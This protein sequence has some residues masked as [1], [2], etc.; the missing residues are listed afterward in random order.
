MAHILSSPV[1]PP[2]PNRACSHP[3]LKALPS[4]PQHSW[5]SSRPRSQT[6]SPVSTSSTPILQ[7]LIDPTCRRLYCRGH[8]QC[9]RHRIG[10]PVYS[11]EQDLVGK[12]TCA[13]QAF[14]LG[15]HPSCFRKDPRPPRHTRIYHPGHATPP[16]RDRGL[17]LRASVPRRSRRCFK[18]LFPHRSWRAANVLTTFFTVHQ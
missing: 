15:R 10:L 11:L 17:G 6:G 18:G 5:S 16:H 7:P 9:S 1:S 4:T 12:Q 13:L 2:P 3:P 8:H 14:R